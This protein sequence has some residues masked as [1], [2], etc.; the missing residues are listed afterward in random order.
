MSR[1]FGG[2]FWKRTSD[3]GCRPIGSSHGKSHLSESTLTSLVVLPGSDGQRT[4]DLLNAESP[5][6][7]TDCLTVLTLS[8]HIVRERRHHVSLLSSPMDLLQGTLDVLILKTLSW[9][10]MHGYAISRWIRQ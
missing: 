4:T 3:K 1:P 5:R 7:R 10:A 2:Q 8:P 6:T 9:E